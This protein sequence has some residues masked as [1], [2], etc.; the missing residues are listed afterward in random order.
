[1]FFV[2]KKDGS[3]RLCIDYRELT[4]VTIKNNYAWPTIDDMVEH[5]NGASKLSKSMRLCEAHC[6]RWLYYVCV[7]D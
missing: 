2:K 7:D 1:M 4:N 5:L 3:M 6:L